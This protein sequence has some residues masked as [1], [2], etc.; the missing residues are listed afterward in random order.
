MNAFLKIDNTFIAGD[1][2]LSAILI[3]LA[4][5]AVS[6]ILIHL[7]V[8]VLGIFTSKIPSILGILLDAYAIILFASRDFSII[9][10]AYILFIPAMFSITVMLPKGV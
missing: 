9:D 8:T 5:I 10:S 6:A 2:K 1:F 7:L 3:P 4:I